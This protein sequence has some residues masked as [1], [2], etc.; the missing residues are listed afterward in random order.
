V[1]N[2]FYLAFDEY[3]EAVTQLV[4]E[5]LVRLNLDTLTPEPAL[6]ESFSAL[7]HLGRFEFILDPR[8]KFSD[9]TPVTAKDVTFTCATLQEAH[10]QGR[11][12]LEFLSFLISCK[13]LSAHKVLIKTH[14]PFP[15]GIASFSQ[16]FILSHKHFSSGTFFKDFNDRYIGSG[17][18]QFNKVIWGKTIELKKVPSYWA[19]KD[20]IKKGNY[21]FESIIFETQPDPKLM[22]RSLL[23]HDLDYVY[24]LSSQSWHQDTQGPLFQSGKIK[25]LE[26]RNKIPFALAGI[27]WNLRKPL[28]QDKNVRHA[29]SLLLDRERLIKDFFFDQYQPISGIAYSGSSYHNPQNSPVKYNPVLA[30]TLLKQSGWNK[31]TRSQF[32][33]NGMVFSFEVLTGNPPAVKYLTFYQESLR[34]VGIELKIK[35]VDW[36]TYIKM[37]NQGQFE[38]IDFSRNRDERMMDLETLWLGKDTAG[39]AINNLFGYSNSRVNK[40]LLNLR[41]VT[42]QSTRLSLIQEIDKT[43]ADDFPM[44]FTWEP[45]FQRIAYWDNFSFAPPGYHGFSRWNNLFVAWKRKQQE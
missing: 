32:E 39:K 27:A 10:K 5:P 8:A 40:L 33:K 18:Y 16:L 36:A 15:Q 14:V 38:A 30:E 23:Q 9:G 4:L 20:A 2:L 35:V 7:P 3:S 17:P 37:R 11:V 13:A 34:Q 1:S 44:A 24:F 22:T 28:F 31:N 29:L 42:N 25:K 26:V 43:I 41:K 19:T 6:A 45:K 21:H 12:V